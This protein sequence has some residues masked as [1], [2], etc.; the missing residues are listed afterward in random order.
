[1]KGIIYGIVILVLV[2]FASGCLSSTEAIAREHS[3]ESGAY[4]YEDDNIVIDLTINK[5]TRENNDSDSISS[6]ELEMTN[7]TDYGLSLITDY[8]SYNTNNGLVMKLVP[9]ETR[10]IH[11]ALTLPQI[12]IPSK[13]TIR[14]LLY[15][16]EDSASIIVDPLL[17]DSY[18]VFGY[19]MGGKE[20]ILTITNKHF[21]RES[22]VQGS[23]WN[24]PTTMLSEYRTV[25]GQVTVEKKNWNILFL[26]SEE[27]RKKVLYDMAF[28]LA[29][30]RYGDDIVLANIQYSG[31]W[32][33]LSL[34]L[35]FSMLGFVEDATATADVLGK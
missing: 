16:T 22:V 11:T 26:Q 29:K 4:R 8:S 10:E 12:A 21:V 13:A 6:V 35:Y 15:F 28:K 5:H 19:N 31:K 33:P 23:L 9:G 32:N 18:L 17:S 1:M 30:E 3:F 7:K 20:T 14:K 2:S 27:G 25:L 24:D 34:V